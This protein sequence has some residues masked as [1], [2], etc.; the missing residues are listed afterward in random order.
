MA[1]AA[2][3][4]H[5]PAGNGTVENGEKLTAAQRKKLKQKQRKQAKKVERYIHMKI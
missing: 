3:V 5:P 1:G 4:A 2:K